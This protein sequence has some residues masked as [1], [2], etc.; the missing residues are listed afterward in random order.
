MEIYEIRRK[1]HK[2]FAF[3]KRIIDDIYIHIDYLNSAIKD[4]SFRGLIQSALS[5][6]SRDDLQL[7][8]VAKINVNRNRLSF[9]QYLNFDEDAFPILNGSWIFEPDKNSFTL[10][11]YAASLNPPILHRKELLVGHDHPLRS[12][13][14]QITKSAEELGLFST[15]NPQPRVRLS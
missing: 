7:C 14:A 4:E 2:E 10:R 3:G 5:A 15:G 1:A 11:S 12:K 8:N 13:W 9:L 6:K